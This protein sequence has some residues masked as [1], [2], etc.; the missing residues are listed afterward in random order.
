MFLFTAP[1]QSGPVP[2]QD[3]FAASGSTI[4]TETERISR[5][6]D[7]ILSTCKKMK[8]EAQAAVDTYFYRYNQKFASAASA[9]T[10]ALNYADFISNLAQE[11]KSGKDVYARLQSI[12]QHC[13]SLE[14][15][16]EEGLKELKLKGW[17]HLNKSVVQGWSDT[18]TR[19]RQYCADIRAQVKEIR[20]SM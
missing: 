9:L 2:C 7:R 8:E 13:Y 11:A 5:N 18:L 4:E 17:I 1:L 6:Y 20:D 16:C 12:D 10:Q 3:P 19:T 14:E 15:D